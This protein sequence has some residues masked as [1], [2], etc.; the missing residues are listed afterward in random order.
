MHAGHGTEQH[1]CQESSY[2]R[3]SSRRKALLSLQTCTAWL[4]A[5]PAVQTTAGHDT[6]LRTE[7]PCSPVA[8]Y[9]AFQ[10]HASDVVFCDRSGL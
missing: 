5:T 6:W 2:S 9:T 8:V 3:Y 4:T 1:Q 10:W 7:L